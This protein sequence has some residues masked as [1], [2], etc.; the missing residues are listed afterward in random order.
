MFEDLG[1]GLR[2]DSQLHFL[3]HTSRALRR[4]GIVGNAGLAQGFQRRVTQFPERTGGVLTFAERFRGKPADKFPL[5]NGLCLRR[6]GIR[7][8][9]NAGD[10]GQQGDGCRKLHMSG[11]MNRPAKVS[12]FAAGKKGNRCAVLGAVS[13]VPVAQKV[14]SSFGL[15]VFLRRHDN[16]PSVSDPVIITS[17][18][19][20]YQTSRTQQ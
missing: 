6:F 9:G 14:G 1:R 19:A 4:L 11:N 13:H 3:K 16:R 5:W 20:S 18:R 2:G 7:R 15:H 12:T 17:V 10:Q 8:E